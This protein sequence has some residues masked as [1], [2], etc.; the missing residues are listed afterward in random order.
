[1][2][3]LI[4]EIFTLPLRCSLVWLTKANSSAFELSKSLQSTEV[5]LLYNY[6]FLLQLHSAENAGKCCSY[7]FCSLSTTTILR[8]NRGV[9]DMNSLYYEIIRILHK[10]RE[11]QSQRNV[12]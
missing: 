10:G 2:S 11:Y 12:P 4:F 6:K 1:M 3:L 9:V 7:R 8:T 5:H